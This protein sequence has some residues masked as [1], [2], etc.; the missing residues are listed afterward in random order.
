M[1]SEIQYVTVCIFCLLAI[2]QKSNSR[3]FPAVILSVTEIVHYTLYD[4]ADGLL[5]YGSDALLD[6]LAIMIIAKFAIPTVLAR[7]LLYI[8][9]ASIIFNYIGFALWITYMS[10]TLYNWSFVVLNLFTIICLIKREPGHGRHASDNN[11]NFI[12]FRHNYFSR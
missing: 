11:G 9:S 8:C 7:Q 3:F 5:Y 4:S 12:V 1:F 6:L 10:P 2:F